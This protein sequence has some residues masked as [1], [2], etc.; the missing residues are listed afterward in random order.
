MQGSTLSWAPCSFYLSPSQHHVVGV[1]IHF[2]IILILQKT[3][4]RSNT[5]HQVTA[6]LRRRVGTRGN[7]GPQTHW[8]DLRE[9]WCL[10][11]RSVP[12]HFA[13]RHLAP[14]LVHWT[15]FLKRR[16]LFDCFL[17]ATWCFGTCLPTEKLLPVSRVNLS[18]TTTSVLVPLWNCF[19]LGPFQAT[20]SSKPTPVCFL[21]LLIS[22]LLLEFPMHSCFYLASFTQNNDFEIHSWCD[23]YWWLISWNLPWILVISSTQSQPII[24]WILLAF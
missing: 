5:S 23:V 17:H 3:G 16:I 15:R 18:I 8:T 2:T 1:T 10:H 6:M 19:P 4:S 21:S 24:L 20:P 13:S 14:R 9:W 7:S 12:L 22:L 11:L